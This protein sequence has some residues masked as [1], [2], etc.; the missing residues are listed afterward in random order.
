MVNVCVCVG[1]GGGGLWI[2]W[3]RDQDAA[4]P[5]GWS[6]LDECHLWCGPPEVGLGRATSVIYD[7]MCNDWGIGIVL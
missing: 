5:N 7:M 4:I 2:Q 3:F 1:G 6:L